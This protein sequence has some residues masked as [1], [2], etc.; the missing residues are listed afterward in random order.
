MHK[1]MVKYL[2]ITVYYI[3]VFVGLNLDLLLACSQYH[4]VFLACSSS[5]LAS[6]VSLSLASCND[7][8][9]TMLNKIN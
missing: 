7:H 2:N 8:K 3:I 4:M 9:K 6:G 1:F 5:I